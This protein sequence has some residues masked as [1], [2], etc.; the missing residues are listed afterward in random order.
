VIALPSCIITVASVNADSI[1]FRTEALRTLF[2]AL[3]QWQIRRAHTD[4]AWD[5]SIVFY[6]LPNGY[7]P[8]HPPPSF[9][10]VFVR[11]RPCDLAW[12]SQTLPIHT[13]TH[14]GHLST[15][16]DLE[17][18]RTTRTQRPSLSVHELSRRFIG[19]KLVKQSGTVE[20]ERGPKLGMPRSSRLRNISSNSE[21][22]RFLD[23]KKW[24]K[25]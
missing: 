25:A 14:I 11:T 24:R 9:I 7:L 19:R 1:A 8:H 2:K 18:R 5:S 16:K 4:A 12:P 22:A 23:L 17:R 3:L 21:Q 13:S 6:T 15:H 10:F 20:I